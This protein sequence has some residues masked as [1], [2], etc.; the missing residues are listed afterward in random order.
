MPDGSAPDLGGAS[1]R[2]EVDAEALGQ[3]TERGEWES[4]L[5]WGA[6]GAGARRETE[7]VAVYWVL[8]N[9]SVIVELSLFPWFPVARVSVPT[10]P[11]TVSDGDT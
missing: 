1:D 10:S 8:C 9:L 3:G 5:Q 7:N 6:A 2:E 11:C 4:E